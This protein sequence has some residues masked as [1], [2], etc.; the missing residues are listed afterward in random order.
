MPQM[1]KN[2]TSASPR[3]YICITQSG[4]FISSGGADFLIDPGAGGALTARCRYKKPNAVLISS[5]RTECSGGFSQLYTPGGQMLFY[6]SSMTKKMMYRQYV[7]YGKLL[8]RAAA[9]SDSSAVEEIMSC[10]FRSRIVI[11]RGKRNQ[12]EVFFYP[13]GSF[14]GMSAIYIRTNQS[15][16]LYTCGGLPSW[17]K[18]PEA[19]VYIIRLR[20]R[21][22]SMPEL[23]SSGGAVI[24][25]GSFSD[26][27]DVISFFNGSDDRTV[28]IDR[29]VLEPACDFLRFGYPVF[30]EKIRPLSG[31]RSDP[32]FIISARSRIYPG[33]IKI[34]SELFSQAP[35]LSDIYA[36]CSK[37]KA[38]KVFVVSPD[39]KRSCEQ[40]RGNIFFC[41]SGT[42]KL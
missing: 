37:D 42:Y 5:S 41:G 20:R 3:Q 39:I 28:G 35:A 9:C 16:I 30:S 33:R 12:A 29:S 6:T 19:E 22:S 4:C 38:K 21:A 7:R 1:E 8:K 13:A 27:F 26:I 23:L 14:P 2:I 32:E 24:N 17:E 18:L 31:C 40:Y 11:N 15:S 10:S 34:P 25:T 36:F